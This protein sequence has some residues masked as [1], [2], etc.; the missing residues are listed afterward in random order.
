MT[1]IEA[2]K[3]KLQCAMGDLW[4]APPNLT[5]VDRAEV[6]YTIDA[7]NKFNCVMRVNASHP[8]I[9]A[10]VQEVSQAHATFDSKFVTYPEQSPTF[11]SLLSSH[12]Y[13]ESYAHDIRYL[14]V[15]K[16]NRSLTP[17][18]TTT[19]VTTKEDLIRLEKT[20]ARAFEVPYQ[21]SSD[22]ELEYIVQEYR[23]SHPRAIRILASDAH[24]GQTLGAGGMSL[25]PALGV[26]FFFGGG[27][28]PEAR[29]RGV[30]SALI[31]A[32]VDYARKRGLE[33]VGIFA[34]QQS[35]SPITAKQGFQKCGEMVYWQ[36]KSQ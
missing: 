27:T 1:K 3:N 19:I 7:E 24:T 14:E 25:F 32:R 33:A 30:Y 6:C 29:N 13:Q 18:I 17:H 8:D 11:F 16:A 36:R 20:Q 21:E 23:K 15:E 10:V 5:V 34:R 2:I 9:E 4:W 26:G 35:S 12:N 28:I 31:T 22:A